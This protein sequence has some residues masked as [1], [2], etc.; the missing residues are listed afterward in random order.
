VSELP[1]LSA[2]AFVYMALAMWAAQPSHECALREEPRRHL[3]LARQLDREHLHRDALTIRAV[4]RRYAS[5]PSSASAG[6]D[7][8]GCEQALARQL[9][10]AHDVSVEEVYGAM[11]EAP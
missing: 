7:I 1:T 5:R 8:A 11:S 2:A 6:P 3:D 9:A 4:A 10:A